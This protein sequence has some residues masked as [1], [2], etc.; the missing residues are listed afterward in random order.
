[1]EGIKYLTEVVGIG[2]SALE[3]KDEKL[4]VLFGENS[5]EELLEFSVAHRVEAGLTGEV[6]AGDVMVI[7]REE[8][9]VTA[10]GDVANKTLEELG[11]VTLRFDG[12]EE[13]QLPGNIHLFPDRFPDIKDGARIL[14]RR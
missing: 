7:D 4:L 6:M 8:Y 5:P 2:P 1:M 10:V 14:I 9:A 11:H 12:A 3:F 13:A